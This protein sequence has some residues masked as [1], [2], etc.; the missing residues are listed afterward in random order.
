MVKSMNIKSYVSPCSLTRSRA[1]WPLLAVSEVMPL[2]RSSIA[3]ILLLDGV[4]EERRV[5]KRRRGED[6]KCDD[7]REERKRGKESSGFTVK[8]NANE[9]ITD[10]IF[11]NIGHNRKA[12]RQEK[13]V[14]TVDK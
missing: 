10:E 4:S 14:E 13:E 3:S 9:I 11:C 12:K 8:Q 7:N 6:E 1:S 2:P 5:E